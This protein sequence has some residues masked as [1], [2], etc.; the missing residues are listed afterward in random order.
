[1]PCGLNPLPVP[2]LV[3]VDYGLCIGAAGKYP[4]QLVFCADTLV[5]S[6]V[7]KLV[8][9]VERNLE[10]QLFVQAPL[11][12]FGHYF[13]ATR[14]AA[15]AVGP[16]VGPQPFA[17]CA[18]MDEQMPGRVEYEQGERTMQHTLAIVA[19]GLVEEARFTV[20]GID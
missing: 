3:G 18:L 11:H 4:A 6:L 2:D 20:F 17:G 7:F 12:G 14:V 15:A 9:K 5:V 19:G 1:M 13:T 16:E 8:E 10:A